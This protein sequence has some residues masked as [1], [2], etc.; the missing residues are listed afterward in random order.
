MVMVKV[1]QTTQTNLLWFLTRSQKASQNVVNRELTNCLILIELKF[2]AALPNDIEIFIIGEKTSTI[3]VNSAHR[4][5]KKS[6]FNQIM[7]E[8]DIKDL[9]QNCR[10]LKN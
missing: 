7:D 6:H 3:F 1:G 9:I 2:L 4:G 8:D 5:F 10:K